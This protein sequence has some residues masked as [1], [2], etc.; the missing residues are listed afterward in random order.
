MGFRLSA[1]LTILCFSFLMGCTNSAV[2]EQ[3]ATVKEKGLDLVDILLMHAEAEDLKLI[4]S[5][6]GGCIEDS[7]VV[8]AKIEDAIEKE[9][10]ESLPK[11]TLGIIS[12]EILTECAR[13]WADSADSMVE[14]RER[15]DLMNKYAFGVE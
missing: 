9:V 15:R 3:T 13:I 4:R 10:T 14:Q 7:G 2:S 12:M 6:V 1:I 11:A 8:E 5:G